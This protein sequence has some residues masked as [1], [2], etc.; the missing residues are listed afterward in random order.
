MIT[1]AAPF[2]AFGVDF[3]GVLHPEGESTCPKTAWISASCRGWRRCCA[4]FLM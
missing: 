3:D 1:A 4:S 2:R